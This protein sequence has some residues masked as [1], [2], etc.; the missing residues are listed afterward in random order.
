[1]KIKIVA[2]GNLKDGYFLDAFKEYQKRMMPFSKIEV[3]EIKEQTHLQNIELI[4][5]KES[6]LILQE[7]EGHS[8]LLDIG[9]KM[10]SS[11]ELSKKFTEYSLG[12]ISKVTFIIGGSY[13]VSEMVR[14]AVKERISFSKMTFPHGLFRVMLIEQIYRAFQIEN[15]TPYH[16]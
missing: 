5:D 7:I 13:G 10:F 1:M 2:V 11:D 14:G 16:K 15:H 8:V 3:K 6:S 12:G 4:K 9:G